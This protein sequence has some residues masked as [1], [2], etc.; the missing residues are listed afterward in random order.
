MTIAVPP[1]GGTLRVALGL[2]T[3]AL[4]VLFAVQV[5][6]TRS[7]LGVDPALMLTL[8]VGVSFAASGL[9]AW[10]RR[11]QNP[12]GRL[13]VALGL[14]WL[15]AR[16]L[17]FAPHPVTFPLG[18][19]LVDAWIIG[20]AYFLFAIPTGRI[21]HRSD[22]WIVALFVV[23]AVPLELLRLLT[24]EPPT[25]PGNALAFFPDPQ[26]GSLIEMVQRVVG[27]VAGAAAAVVL[28]VRL[29]RSSAPA[30]RASLPAVV[31]AFAMLLTLSLTAL[32]TLR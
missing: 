5:L 31:G 32:S 26:L 8:L 30:R 19:W 9:Y 17:L 23:M 1:A 24:L 18:T 22:T 29:A 6:T 10:G 4:A 16:C 27:M 2:A 12:L 28:T 25:G 14:V 20:L 21:V 11:P 7:A 3:V 15:F 13:M